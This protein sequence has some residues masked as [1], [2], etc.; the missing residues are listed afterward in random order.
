MN[1]RMKKL[2]D[3]LQDLPTSELIDIIIQLTDRSD[4]NTTLIN[5]LLAS[6]HPKKLADL[7]IKQ[8]K[9]LSKTAPSYDY[10]QSAALSEQIYDIVAQVD[11]H[12]VKK[13][14]DLAV[15]I[16]K[17][18]IKIDKKLFD[19]ID[20]SYGNLGSAYYSL[21]ETLDKA[22]AASNSEPEVIAKYLIETYLDDDYGNR[23]D[24][25]RQIKTCLQGEKSAALETI[26]GNY[27]MKDYQKADIRKKVADLSGNVSKYIE[28]IKN[29][30]RVDSSDICDIAERLLKAGQTEQSIDWLM[31]IKKTDFR[32]GRKDN[33]LIK[34]YEHLGNTEKAQELRWDIFK[35]FCFIEYYNEYIKRVAKED[36]ESVEKKAIKLAQE[37]QSLC[38]GVKFLKEIKKY[39]L[40]NDLLLKRFDEVDGQDYHTYR[41]LS[42]TLAKQ[43]QYLIASLLRRKLAR[44]CVAKSQSKY[45]RYAASDYKLCND[46]A[47]E[48]TDWQG[49]PSHD[50]FLANFKET[51][52]RKKA[53]WAMI[54]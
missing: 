2:K 37:T 12:L 23:S 35:E 54:K 39:D 44:G 21:Y 33:L 14:P 7:L 24:I 42:T 8:V 47:K 1:Q 19:H 46:Y 38:Y 45:Y 16:L 9:S 52:K 32:S 22:F 34:A 29:S 25:I 3:E 15:Q 18:L 17:L 40:L 50:A 43:G 53:F 51:H 30:G 10:K 26:M 5:T 27:Q 31:K 13:A 11:D 4:K 36:R 28:A 49:F 6:H 41:S 20:D 48:V